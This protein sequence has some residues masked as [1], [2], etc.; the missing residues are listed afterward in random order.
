MLATRSLA[1][2]ALLLFPCT[3]VEAQRGQ[4]LDP[5]RSARASAVAFTPG[6]L[7]V[8]DA[9]NVRE[10]T[11]DGEFVQQIPVPH[12]DTTRYDATDAVVDRRGRLHVLNIAPF[13]NDYISTFDTETGTWEH[14]PITAFLGNIS[15]GDLHIRGEVLFTKSLA[16]PLSDF[17]PVPIPQPAFLSVAEYVVAQSGNLFGINA[18]SPRFEVWELDPLDFSL[19][20]TRTLRDSF[21]FRLSARGLAL[22]RQGGIFAA[23]WDGRIYEYDDD[24]NYLRDVPTGANNLTNID[25]SWDGLLTVGS[26][27]GQVVVTDRSLSSI[28]TFPVGGS[29]L[30]SGFVPPRELRIDFDTSFGAELALENGRVVDGGTLFDGLVEI[31]GTAASGNRAALFDSAPLG[32]NAFADDPDLLVDKGNVLIL[33]EAGA[34]SVAGVYDEPDDD[35]FGGTFRIVF[36]GIPVAPCSIDLIDICPGVTE[37]AFLTLVDERGRERRYHVPAGWT[38]DPFLEG[39]AGWRTL[40]LRSTAPQP[41]HQAIATASEDEGF[42][43]GAVTELRIELEGSG[44][45][46]DLVFQP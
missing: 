32:P 11:R 39:G 6:N 10:Y 4:R 27:F 3:R 31:E 36:P 40:D 28:L 33:Q 19:L 26:R 43:A 37:D 20:R 24:A 23:D 35:R 8:T 38:E 9:R 46:D 25:V 17:V 21:G 13:S 30:Y 42:D 12:P 7:L 22:P 45:I 16:I 44:A 14:H 18:G 34:Q 29:L 41:G 15:D 1:L 5:G 2:A